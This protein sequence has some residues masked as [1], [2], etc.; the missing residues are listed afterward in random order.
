MTS[1]KAVIED[2]FNITVEHQIN[3]ASASLILYDFLQVTPGV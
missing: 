1:K 3:N 2:S